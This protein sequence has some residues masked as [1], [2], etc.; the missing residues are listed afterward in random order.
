MR[1][2]SAGRPRP[3]QAS[4][5]ATPSNT[6]ARCGVLPLLA[7]HPPPWSSSNS[8]PKILSGLGWRGDNP[9]SDMEIRYSAGH[10]QW[11]RSK[12]GRLVDVCGANVTE[13]PIPKY[14][15][16]CMCRI[17]VWW[18]FRKMAAGGSSG[19]VSE[20]S[21]EFAFSLWLGGQKDCTSIP[22]KLRGD[23]LYP[24]RDGKYLGIPLTFTMP[25][26]VLLV[27]SKVNLGRRSSVQ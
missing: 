11:C 19:L 23:A 1:C 15:L 27:T 16:P 2:Y 20:A 9:S 5:P 13:R 8:C 4:R 25:T 10:N 14:H 12:H 21:D 7:F 17:L 26:S 6:K 18:C 22:K 3:C 24:V